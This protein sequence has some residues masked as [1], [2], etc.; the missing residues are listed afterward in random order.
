MSEQDETTPAGPG[1]RESQAAWARVEAKLDIYIAG[2]SGWRD[3]V[4]RRLA[5]HDSMH[6]QTAQTLAEV[7]LKQAAQ[8]AV[9]GAQ[10]AE[11]PA[12]ASGWTVAAVVVASLAIASNVILALA[13][14]L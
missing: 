2:M 9:D 8:S 7:Q 5:D 4:D 10:A 13:L 1:R 12:K 3:G 14:R 6:R 11:K